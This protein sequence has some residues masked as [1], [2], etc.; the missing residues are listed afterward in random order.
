[1]PQS[2]VETS[3]VH[4]GL[5][6]HS[7]LGFAAAVEMGVL[8]GLGL[9]DLLLA[10]GL[11]PFNHARREG[12]H[13]SVVLDNQ[14]ANK[15]KKLGESRDLSTLWVQLPNHLGERY[16]SLLGKLQDLGKDVQNRIHQQ[17]SLPV[18]M[19]GEY[20][21]K[22]F[23]LLGL[24]LAFSDDFQLQLQVPRIPSVVALPHQVEVL[25]EVQFP[26]AVLIH[27]MQGH[28][29]ILLTSLGLR[30]VW[31]VLSQHLRQLT[32]LHRSALVLIVRFEAGPQVGDLCLRV[33]RVRVDFCEEELA[34]VFVESFELGSG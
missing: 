16:L 12:V 3:I 34:E 14:L 9:S 1:M 33:A 13:T 26:I 22:S 25:V 20:L 10:D 29:D 19:F 31:E 7:G 8:I 27:L 24:E 4:R 30:G 28:D 18:D 15:T 32:P 21:P 11:I 5:C 6:A 17:F 2:T 23:N